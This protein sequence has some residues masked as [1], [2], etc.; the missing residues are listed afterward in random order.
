MT[1]LAEFLAATVSTETRRLI[2]EGYVL[3]RCSDAKLKGRYLV[4]YSDM[5]VCYRCKKQRD[6]ALNMMTVRWHCPLSH[7]S[8]R[9]EPPRN[10]NRVSGAES[11]KSVLSALRATI[12]DL[13]STTPRIAKQAGRKLSNLAL[14][15][16]VSVANIPVIVSVKSKNGAKTDTY[17]FLL[18][19]ELERTIWLQLLD[20]HQE[21][22]A[23]QNVSPPT[24]QSL[25]QIL[26]STMKKDLIRLDVNSPV[27]SGELSLLV[28]SAD[29]VEESQDLFVVVET[30]CYG[31]FHHVART[32]MIVQCHHPV[33][34]EKLVFRLEAA[35]QLRMMLF[36]Q[37]EDCNILRGLVQVPISPDFL[38]STGHACQVGNFESVVPIDGNTPDGN[39]NC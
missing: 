5:L 11:M 24:H 30:D 20:Q 16:N 23:R 4:L 3:E 26:K 10:K 21:V 15:L 28:S 29:G 39:L 19:S 6:S 38:A 32:K 13:K 37:K 35:S 14:K 36:A 22:A 2:K 17:S 31:E 34:N 7:L 25:D 18:A 27:V 8:V 33:W 1:T 12:K 9:T